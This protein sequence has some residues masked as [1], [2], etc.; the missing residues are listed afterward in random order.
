MSR[1]LPP[2]MTVSAQFGHS[3]QSANARDKQHAAR[4]DVDE[5]RLLKIHSSRFLFT[6]LNRYSV[7]V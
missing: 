6:V 5:I 2:A 4:D 3:L 7:C 1:I